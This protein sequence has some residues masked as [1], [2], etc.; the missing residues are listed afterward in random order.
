MIPDEVTNLNTLGLLVLCGTGLLMLVLPRRYAL[1][2]VIIVTCFMTLGQ[3]VLVGGLHFTMIRILVLFGWVRL[4]IRREFRPIHLNAVDKSVLAWTLVAIITHS[5]LWQTSDEFINRLGFG[6]NVLGMY[7]LFRFL[8]RSLEDIRHTFAMIAI[9]VLPLAGAMLLER[10][11]ERNVFAVFGGV[12]AVTELRGG[13]LR[14]QGP[15][16][17]PILAGTFGASLLPLL[18]S[19]WWQGR[20][21]KW[22]AVIGVASAT[23]IVATSGS[24]GPLMAYLAGCLGL[25]MWYGRRHMRL[26][27]W[28][29]LLS[30]IALALVMKAPVWYL[31]QRVNI[32]SGSNGDH[33]ALL[34][35][36]FV[37]HFSDWWLL[38]VKSTI[39]WADENMWDITNQFVWEGVM[40]GLAEMALFI[41]IIVFCFRTVGK[42]IHRLPA[43]HGHAQRRLVW[44]LGATV[45]VHMASFMSISY[46]DQNGINWYLLLALIAAAAAIR[47]TVPAVVLTGQEAVVFS[48]DPDLSL[49]NSKALNY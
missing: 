48:A 38:G 27:R 24:S 39:G 43:T 32:F 11:T 19:L 34:I 46:F 5:L 12:R 13:T 31:I 37:R 14:C 40:G 20:R 6:Y 8:L 45:F 25:L 2:P 15:F 29:I 42:A 47:K 3:V 17:H 44:A 18:A 16:G 7:F 49:R 26:V 1:L 30:F 10:F 41:T 33:R 22:L 21:Y 4:F 35:D 9:T 23:V 36:Q 28:G